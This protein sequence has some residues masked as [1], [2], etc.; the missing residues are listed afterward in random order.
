MR[1]SLPCVGCCRQ[2]HDNPIDRYHSKENYKGSDVML[3]SSK[4]E[5]R[6]NHHSTIKMFNPRAYIK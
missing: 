2:V 1:S 6:P 4:T 3:L 5:T